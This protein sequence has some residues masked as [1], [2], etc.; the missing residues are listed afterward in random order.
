MP[1]N[2]ETGYDTQISVEMIRSA[3]HLDTQISVQ[4]IRSAYHLD[5]QFRIKKKSKLKMTEKSL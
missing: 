2:R 5:T 3:Y 4:I 1:K